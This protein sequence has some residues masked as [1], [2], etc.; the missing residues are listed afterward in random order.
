MSW[1]REVMGFIPSKPRDVK[2]RVLSKKTVI[3]SVFVI[4]K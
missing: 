2:I 4:Q 3:K 1:P